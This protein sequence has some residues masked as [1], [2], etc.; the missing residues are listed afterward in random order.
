MDPIDWLNKLY[1]LYLAAVVGVIMVSLIG[2]SRHGYRIRAYHRNQPNKS[3]LALYK[4][5]LYCISCLCNSCT[6]V[7]RWSDS[8]VMMSVM[9]MYRGI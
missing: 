3:K 1:S 7:T 8:V 6:E 9:Y 4:L 2:L 5:L